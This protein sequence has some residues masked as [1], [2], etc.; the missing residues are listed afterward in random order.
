[1]ESIIVGVDDY[2]VVLDVV[3]VYVVVVA[4][5]VIVHVIIYVNVGDLLPVSIYFA[6]SAIS[7]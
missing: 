3:A 2:Y 6:V 1:M 7:L 5:C 4:N